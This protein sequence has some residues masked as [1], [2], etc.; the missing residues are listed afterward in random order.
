MS[1]V[2]ATR[3]YLYGLDEEYRVIRFNSLYS[4]L[5]R[6]AK[7]I[8][9]ASMLQDE[10][11]GIRMVYAVEDCRDIYEACRESMKTRLMD[12]RV[13]FKVL[14]DQTGIKLI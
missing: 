8:S 2:A 5:E 14:L 10:Y 7:L 11:F 1:N 12:D 3:V 13:T 9:E 4:N 6:S